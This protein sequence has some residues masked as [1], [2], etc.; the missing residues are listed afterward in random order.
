MLVIK[1][2]LESEYYL[3]VRLTTYWAHHVYSI[4]F[5]FFFGC[6]SA[7]K[8]VISFS[9]HEPGTLVRR[10]LQWLKWKNI[11]TEKCIRSIF[12]KFEET[13]SVLNAPKSGRPP[14]SS[15]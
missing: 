7:C 10:E 8:I 2:S 5:G 4:S 1:N 15:V 9:K 3:Y 14:V 12:K 11:P 6:K 13:E